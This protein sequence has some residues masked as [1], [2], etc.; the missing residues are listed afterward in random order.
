[1]IGFNNSIERSEISFD[2][3]SSITFSI[4]ILSSLSIATV[5]S[6][7]LSEATINSAI[8]LITFLLLSFIVTPNFKFSTTSLMI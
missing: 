4:P 8:P 7:I 5:M 2:F 6:I 3:N 1:M